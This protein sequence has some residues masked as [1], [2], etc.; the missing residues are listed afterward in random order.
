MAVTNYN[1]GLTTIIWM[2]IGE[3]VQKTKNWEIM[4]KFC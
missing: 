3:Q 2:S 1:E 4:E